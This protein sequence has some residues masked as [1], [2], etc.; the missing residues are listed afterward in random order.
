MKSRCVISCSRVLQSSTRARARERTSAANWRASMRRA[1]TKPRSR[2]IA[3]ISASKAAARIDSLSRPPVF[4]SPLPSWITSPSPSARRLLG[5]RARVHQRRAQLRE[6]ALVCCGDVLHQQ[7]AHR[8][9]EHGVAEELELLVVACAARSRD[10]RAMRERGRRAAGVAEVVAEAL[11]DR[12]VASPLRQ[13][14]P[15]SSRRRAPRR[16][17]EDRRLPG[18]HRARRLVEPARRGRSP[19]CASRAATGAWRW[20]M[21]TRSRGR[22]CGAP[23]SS[24]RARRRA[25]G[26]RARAAAPTC[27]VAGRAVDRASRSAATPRRR[28]GRGAGRR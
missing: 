1:A 12:R 22:R 9:L 10:D 5:E 14:P 20:R 3:P 8:E 18:R 25:R 7:I 16:R 11:L 27:T 24:A 15:R 23:A 13:A 2:K 4:S 28:R 19:A 6:L 17:V 21:R 26:S